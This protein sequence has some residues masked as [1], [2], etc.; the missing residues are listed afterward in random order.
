MRLDTD[1]RPL[2]IL[3]FL[4][5]TLIGCPRPAEAEV[6]LPLYEEILMAQR[7]EP[8]EPS[9]GNWTLD[10]VLSDDV[11]EGDS[12]SVPI[13]PDPAVAWRSLAAGARSKSIGSASKGRL[14][15]G[16]FMPKKG[17]GFR[18]KNEKAPWGTDETVALLTWA[19]AE[20]TR[21]YPGTVPV[22]VGDLSDEDGGRLR[23]HLSHQSGRDADVGYYFKGNERVT[24]FKTATRADMDAEKTWT[25]LELLLSTGQVQYLFIDRKLHKPL[26]RQ[27]LAMGWSDAEA[28]QLFESPIGKAKRSG[29]IRHI[30]GHK[31]HFHVRF[32]C[33]DDD[34][35]C[36]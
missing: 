16:R 9:G 5:V 21:R 1:Y 25:L 8:P 31:H 19:A 28:R 22:V 15:H 10:R 18:R 23:P 6:D 2:L 4:A 34:E 36:N 17:A 33:P 20:M 27:A 32:R 29:V 30:S 26:F 3:A 35:R 11:E 14:K 13:L 24:H 7:Q 12:I